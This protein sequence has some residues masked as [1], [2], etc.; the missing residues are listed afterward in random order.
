MNEHR[1]AFARQAADIL[2]R[3]LVDGRG[4][5]AWDGRAKSR[6]IPSARKGLHDLGREHPLLDDVMDVHRRAL[7]G[8]C[9]RFLE[10]AD[11]QFGV[12]G[13]G[14]RPCQFD[15]FALDG[16]EARQ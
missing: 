7:S 3:R 14:K 6:D 8:D 13:R 15:A 12:H 1:S 9:D 2:A 16:R 4:D 5:H 10:T 11:F